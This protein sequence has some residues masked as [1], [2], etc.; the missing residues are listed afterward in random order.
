MRGRVSPARSPAK[1]ELAFD[2]LVSIAVLHYTNIRVCGKNVK[3][4]YQF[5]E[6]ANG[7][8]GLDRLIHSS[9]PGIPHGWEQGA[10]GG[11]AALADR[12]VV[13]SKSCVHI[14]KA[15]PSGWLAGW[16]CVGRLFGEGGRAVRCGGRGLGV[17]PTGVL[18]WRIAG[19]GRWAELVLLADSEQRWLALPL[20]GC[21]EPCG[22]Q[23]RGGY[24]LAVAGQ[25]L[26]LPA[27][28]C[29]AALAEEDP[30]L[31]WA[32]SGWLE[33]CVAKKGSLDKGARGWISIW[34]AR[35]RS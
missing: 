17:L 24:C 2:K 11:R 12:E 3:S 6:G 28:C 29:H 26:V 31:S 35:T 13:A 32:C 21:V 22:A 30:G 16:R 1:S 18:A 4:Q 8:A 15:L 33:S 19:E 27:G 25:D 5:P 9:D 34:T 23:R 14:G 20:A 10:A 7:W